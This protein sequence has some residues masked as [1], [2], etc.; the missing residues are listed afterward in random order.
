MGEPPKKVLKCKKKH[1]FSKKKNMSF[2]NKGEGGGGP[3][4]GKNSHIFPFFFGGSVP[5]GILPIH[6]TSHTIPYRINALA[7]FLYEYVARP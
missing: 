3:P 4:L 2:P 5:Y 7:P 1:D 6:I